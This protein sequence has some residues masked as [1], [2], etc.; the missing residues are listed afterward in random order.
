MVSTSHAIAGSAVALQGLVADYYA[1]ACPK[2]QGPESACG[3]GRVS[4]LQLTMF[5]LILWLIWTV[6]TVLGAA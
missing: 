4:G 5:L 1:P 6:S 3:K 2:G